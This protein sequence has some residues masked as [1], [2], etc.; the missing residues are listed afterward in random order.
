MNAVDD[1]DKL[2]LSFSFLCTILSSDK[3]ALISY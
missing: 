1:S 3:L 2:V